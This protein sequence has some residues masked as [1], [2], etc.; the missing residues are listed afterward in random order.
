MTAT[1]DPSQFYSGLIA[2]LYEPLAGELASADVYIPFLDQSGSPA[3][4]LACGSGV[5]L[6]DLVERGYDVDGLDASQDMLDRCHAAA[7][8]RGIDI[9]IHLAKMQSFSLPRRY[10]SMFLAGASFTL[11]CSDGD[12]RDALAC[13]CSH[14]EPG[15]SVLIPLEIPN[16]PANE[17][18]IG[19]V[20]EIQ[21]DSG[22]RLR[23]SMV[24][25]ELSADGRDTCSRLRYER[26]SAGGESDIVERDWHRRCWSQEQFREMLVTA[27]FDK[28]TF[29]L[30]HGGRAT[31]DAPVFVAL[32]RRGPPDKNLT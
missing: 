29:V 5:P 15:G 23:V 25:F 28:I 32:A 11:L 1:D 14:L 13:M 10:R 26:I 9:S 27:G 22:D 7:G 19:Q 31:P 3:L 21:T 12:A 24:A 17:Q 8:E 16:V 30:P 2:D 6:L 18:A 20:R 4:E